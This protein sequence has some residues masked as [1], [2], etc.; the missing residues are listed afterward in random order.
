MKIIFLGDS[1]TA[2]YGLRAEE[3][4]PVLLTKVFPKSRQFINAGINGNTSADGLHRLEQVLSHRP[5]YLA[6]ALGANDM[7]RGV[8]V[9]Q[10]KRNLSEIVE[11]GTRSGARAL[12]LGMQA[13]PFYGAQYAAS[14]NRIYFELE[15]RFGIPHL[16]FFI[17]SVALKQHLNLPDGVHPNAEGHREIAKVVSQFISR[18]L[19]TGQEVVAAD[20]R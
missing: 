12:L 16:P 7:L 20:N 9:E 14:F 18:V 5:D 17:E 10:V 15:K 1:L 13:V 6:I 3:T 8:P 4:Y 19:A 2:G 11:R